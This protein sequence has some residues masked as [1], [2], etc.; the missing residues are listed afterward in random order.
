MTTKLQTTL[1]KTI[2]S[3]YLMVVALFATAIA[4]NHLQ[5]ITHEY[6]LDYN[7]TGMLVTTAT[8]AEGGNPY[9]L[10]SQPIRI[11]LYPVLYNI[12]VAPLTR[13]FGNT[14]ELHRAVNGLFLLASCA[15]CFY[16]CR[17]DSGTRT[18]SFTAAVL[19]YA[20]LLVYSTPIASTNGLGLFLFLGAIT[21]PWVHGFSTRSLAVSI[22][23][24]ILAYHTKQYFIASL[25]YVAL[26]LFLA[27]SKK[28]AIYFSL[29]ALVAFIVVLAIVTYTSPYYLEATVFAVQSS[30]KMAA[31]DEH[32]VT[33]VREFVQIYLPL[34]VILIVV[35]VYS[36]YA[37]TLVSEQSARDSQQSR[38]VNLF[39]LDK[40]LLQYKPNYIWV[41]CA[42]SVI[43]I[44][45]ALGKN[46]GNHLT[47]FFQFISPFL[48]AGIFA[49]ISGM[50]KW[51]W[52]FRILI[53]IALYN[54]YV[55]L[56]SNFSLKEDSWRIVKTEIASAN[57][58][59]ASTLV[60]QYVLDKGA[61]VY[62]SPS[63]R[64]YVAANDKPSFF[65]DIHRKDTV[66]EIWER[67]VNLIQGK[68][69]NREF[70]LLLIDNW[71]PFPTSI[72]NSGKGA[73]T[74]EE[75]LQNIG[76]ETE[77]QLKA[78]YKMTAEI[79]LPL[80]KRPGGGN[81]QL[82]IWK[83]IEGKTERAEVPSR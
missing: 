43:I 39:N 31:S 21:I 47:Y 58:I 49:L 61:P 76:K 50:P 57:E 75:S 55:M 37:K 4:Y 62:L 69:R 45:L 15:I 44:V 63:T 71:M 74:L 6:T 14:L 42:C 29:A 54:N 78:N 34:L 66:P 11:S 16:L 2:N 10:E 56:P 67:Y 19:V 18:E 3:L 52:P 79:T 65:N 83:P 17:R 22:V 8:I 80:V 13:V 36:G 40:P 60:L 7:E 77:N 64:Y 25:G 48:L 38:V 72:Q 23:F 30:T 73:E 1:G 28:R 59:Y 82:Q 70:D 33:Q 26:Y 32:L 46:R 35:V 12:L 51:R 9:S 81:Y 20:G 27:E 68:I 24:G 53:L 5:I 41:C